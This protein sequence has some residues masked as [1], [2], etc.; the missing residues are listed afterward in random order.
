M[1]TI[2]EGVLAILDRSPLRNMDIFSEKAFAVI[3]P[4]HGLNGIYQINLA[5]KDAYWKF[6]TATPRTFYIPQDR[7]QFAETTPSGDPDYPLSVRYY[8]G[9]IWQHRCKYPELVYETCI[10]FSR[11]CG[12]EAMKTTS[13]FVPIQDLRL[14]TVQS[15]E[16]TKP[17]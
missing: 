5:Q 7:A 2:P 6:T 11:Q 4:V 15:I 12:F 3:S 1:Q 14:D 13:I 17:M 10:E 16:L 9:E 8:Q